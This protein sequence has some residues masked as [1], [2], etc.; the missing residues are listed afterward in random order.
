MNYVKKTFPVHSDRVLM[1][2]QHQGTYAITKRRQETASPKHKGAGNTL[3]D[4]NWR[5]RKGGSDR[6]SCEVTVLVFLQLVF[7]VFL[8]LLP[9]S[10][11][12]V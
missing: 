4:P 2:Q 5:E 6:Q 7:Y 1:S 12:A 8:S 10:L 9:V 11:T 3:I